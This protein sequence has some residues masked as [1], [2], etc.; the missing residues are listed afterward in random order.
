MKIIYEIIN[1]ENT[2]IQES[3][4]LTTEQIFLLN[5]FLDKSKKILNEIQE[6]ITNNNFKKKVRQIYILFHDIF[7]LKDKKYKSKL[8][9]NKNK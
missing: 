3:H 5:E 6:I 1:E 8:Y 7:E 2:N 4:L 9:Y